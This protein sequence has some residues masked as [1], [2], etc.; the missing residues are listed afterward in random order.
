MK[1]FIYM[2]LTNI[3]ISLPVNNNFSSLQIC[4]RLIVK[5]IVFLVSYTPAIS[6]PT[7]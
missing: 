2:S 3:S 6:Q 7:I 5:I 4:A 1:S